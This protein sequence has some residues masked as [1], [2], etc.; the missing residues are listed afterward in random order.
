MKEQDSQRMAVGDIV[1]DKLS[2]SIMKGKK[3]IFFGRQRIIPFSDVLHV[4]ASSNKMTISGSWGSGEV[5]IWE[6][7]VELPG[8]NMV[9]IDGITEQYPERLVVAKSSSKEAMF[10]LA[11]RINNFIGRK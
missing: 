7:I 3:S 6:T 1:I 4:H 5:T 2:K 9:L 10:A 8:H 11:D